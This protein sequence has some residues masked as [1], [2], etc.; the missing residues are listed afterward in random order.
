[1]KIKVRNGELFATFKK[2]IF[3]PVKSILS[4]KPSPS[5]T[6]AVIV[7]DWGCST[8]ADNYDEVVAA[9]YGNDKTR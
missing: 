7:T 4:V 6:G 2:I 3:V 9:L 1:M 5:G 8:V